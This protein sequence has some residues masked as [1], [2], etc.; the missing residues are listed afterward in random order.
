MFPFFSPFLGF[1]L[2][3]GLFEVTERRKNRMAQRALRE[4]LISELEHIEVMLSSLV[5]AFVHLAKTHEEIE[6][7]RRKLFNWRR[8]LTRLRV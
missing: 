7:D 3:W 2:G 8:G 1:L 4:A 5:G 6:P